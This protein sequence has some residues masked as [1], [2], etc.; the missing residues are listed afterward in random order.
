LNPDDDIIQSTS[1][2]Y[3]YAIKT[4]GTSY[5]RLDILLFV[6]AASTPQSSYDL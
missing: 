5:D 2:I 3:L 4:V 1:A 6:P